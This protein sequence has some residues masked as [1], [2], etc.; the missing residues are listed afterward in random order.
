[1][2]VL[3]VPIVRNNFR[4]W[5]QNRAY[6]DTA[7]RKPPAC[8][9]P[10]RAHLELRLVISL[11]SGNHAAGAGL[12]RRIHPFGSRLPLRPQADRP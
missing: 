8:H 4:K 2:A 6:P 7:A 10:G 3:L 11:K 12:W 1:M 9:E 5:R